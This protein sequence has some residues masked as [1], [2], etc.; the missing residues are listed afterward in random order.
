MAGVLVNIPKPLRPG[1][2]FE[3]KVLIQHP[4]ENGFRRNAMGQAIPRNII[5]SFR[6]TYNG[7]EVFAAD[8]QPAIAANPFLSFFAVATGSGEIE[9][10][11]T[12]DQDQTTVEHVAIT[13]P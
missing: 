3:V 11:W 7:E 4:M 13:V 12:D 10:T 5:H 9:L 6:C 8:L 2:V 1:Q